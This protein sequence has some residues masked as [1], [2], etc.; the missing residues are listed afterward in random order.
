MSSV[1]DMVSP[2]T[3][4]VKVNDRLSPRSSP[5][6]L[7]KRISAPSR[8]PDRSRDYEVAL[9]ASVE[10]VAALAQIAACA[11]TWTPRTR[12]VAVH[13]PVTSA[14]GAAGA[15]AAVAAGAVDEQR[16]AGDRQSPRSS[17]AAI[18]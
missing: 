12:C 4:P 14:A 16:R 7:L 18:M 6:P 10:G 17:P 1:P 11:W 5:K 8:L 15:A 9:V 2:K 3:A 13:S